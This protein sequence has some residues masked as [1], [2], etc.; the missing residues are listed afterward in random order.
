MV[1]NIHRTKTNCA[2]FTYVIR[3]SNSSENDP[4]LCISKNKANEKK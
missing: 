1:G 2:D 4:L 3:V